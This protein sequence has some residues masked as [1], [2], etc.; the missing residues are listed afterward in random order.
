MKLN[1]RSTLLVLL[2]VCMP[3]L[4][5]GQTIHIHF[6]DKKKTRSASSKKVVKEPVIR[7]TPTPDRVQPMPSLNLPPLALPAFTNPSSFSAFAPQNADMLL[8]VRPQQLLEYSPIKSQ[9]ALASTMIPM[10]ATGSKMENVELV[11]VASSIETLTQTMQRRQEQ[12]MAR[13]KAQLDSSA[14]PKVESTGTD[15][16]ENFTALVRFEKAISWDKVKSYTQPFLSGSTLNVQEWRGLEILAPA[17]G[18]PGIFVKLD[19]RTFLLCNRNLLEQN[20]SANNSR[21]NNW[22]SEFQDADSGFDGDLFVAGVVPK[23]AIPTSPMQSDS[24][25]EAN[26]SEIKE[27]KFSVDVE[28]QAMLNVDLD[29][30]SSKSASAFLR[31]ARKSL[32]EGIQMVKMF[33][34]SGSG[35][36][37][38]NPFAAKHAQ[39]GLEIINSVHL[40]RIDSTANVSFEKPSN[41]ER[42]LEEFYS[43]VHEIGAA[44]NQRFQ[45]EGFQDFKSTNSVEMQPVVVATRSIEPGELLSEADLKVENWPAKLIPSGS[46]KG[47]KDAIGKTTRRRIFRG[48]PIMKSDFQ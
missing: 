46:A 44:A 19:E 45:D 14:E 26:L 29:F 30:G 13:I 38:G 4:C 2:F 37:N 41:F 3:S 25:W 35:S 24:G 48:A 18:D 16:Q 31:E 22:L 39:F 15:V 6:G 11:I 28:D 7:A 20:L 43:D 32:N 40:S 12:L 10:P 36:S 42:K 9:L 33:Q 1:T 5:F 21:I 23:D 47:S 27:V 8:I 17:S 34:G